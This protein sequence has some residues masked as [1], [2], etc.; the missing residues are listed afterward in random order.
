[1]R[2]ALAASAV[3]LAGATGVLASA[4]APVTFVWPSSVAVEPS[5]SLLVVENGLHRLVRVDPKTGH[6]TQLAALT[7]PFAVQRTA[8]GTTYVTDG[9]L[10]RRFVG[11]RTVVVTRASGDIGP[12]A[13]DRNGT[14]YFATA[15]ALFAL[16]G[17]KGP[18]VRIAPGTR[19]SNPHGLG[20]EPDERLV[21]SDTNAHRL[22]LVE[23]ASGQTRVLAHVEAPAGLAIG[24]DGSIYVADIGTSRVL[25]LNSGGKRLGFV[26]KVFEDP[27]DVELAPG[28]VVYVVESLA[29]GD[30]RRVAPNGTVTTVSSR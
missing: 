4:S 12:I 15:N 6:V 21:V 30:L 18:A 11:T 27:Y 10:L 14:V 29:V 22:L 23:P 24:S 20:V 19:F 2:I 17:G 25:H 1:M 26:G 9:P 8:S 13:I 7:K 16:P 5:G 28:R 3:F